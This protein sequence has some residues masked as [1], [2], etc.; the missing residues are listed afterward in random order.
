MNKIS[1]ALLLTII[2]LLAFVCAFGI[3][4]LLF[5]TYTDRQTQASLVDTWEVD[6]FLTTVVLGFCILSALIAGLCYLHNRRLAG[7][8]ILLAIVSGIIFFSGNYILT[9]RVALITGHS[10]GL[11]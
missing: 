1:S 5:E 9:K 6:T 4:G 10:V 8:A 2:V 7:I 3:F 11:F